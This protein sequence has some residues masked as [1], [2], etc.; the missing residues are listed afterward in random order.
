MQPHSK[1]THKGTFIIQVVRTRAKNEMAS[2]VL[3]KTSILKYFRSINRVLCIAFK[4]AGVRMCGP[5]SAFI[6]EPYN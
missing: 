3:I 1:S 5:W 4:M 6:F 2:K